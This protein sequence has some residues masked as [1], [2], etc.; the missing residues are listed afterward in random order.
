M[1][2]IDYGESN[3][4]HLHYSDAASDEMI[5][6]ILLKDQVLI[7]MMMMMIIMTI[8]MMMLTQTILIDRYLGRW[9]DG[10]KHLNSV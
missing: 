6:I 1:N 7:M 3:I 10:D 4:N 9:V 2:S 8:M 5:K